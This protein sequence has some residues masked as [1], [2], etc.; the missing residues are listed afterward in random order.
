[1]AAWALVIIVVGGGVWLAGTRLHLHP[2]LGSRP[3]PGGLGGMHVVTYGAVPGMLPLSS[4]RLFG[5]PSDPF[6]GTPADNWADGA[7]G[8]V[9]PRGK[10]VGEY[11]ASQVSYAYQTTKKLLA[12]AALDKRTLLG[13]A[14]TAFTSL[15]SQLNRT[16]FMGDLNKIGL[17][18]KGEAVSS[19]AEII[20]FAPGTTKLIGS[21]IKVHGTMSARATTDSHGARVLEVN[22]NYLVTYPVEPPSA[23][24]NWMRVVAHFD[25]HVTFGDWAGAQT[26]FEPW[27]TLGRSVAGI[28]CSTPDGYVHP[29]FPSG[30]P[31]QVQPSGPPIDPYSLRQTSHGACWRTTGT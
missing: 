7:A 22:V 16:Q 30:P 28:R 21:V 15:L 14:P 19:R 11:S 18:K 9:I 25:G 29:D 10:P 12:A 26:P 20:S 31:D 3:S 8:I 17:D 13:G 4:A 24:Q 23:P 27:W 6:A 2:H 1:V 5:P